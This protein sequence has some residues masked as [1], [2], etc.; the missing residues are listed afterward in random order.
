MREHTSFFPRTFR[1]WNELPAS[2][3]S[4]AEGAEDFVARITSL[5]NFRDRS[6]NS[7]VLMKDCLVDVSQVTHSYSVQK[8]SLPD[9]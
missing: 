5:V 9:I 2:L 6:S 8:I 4:T 3:L 7:S 1:E